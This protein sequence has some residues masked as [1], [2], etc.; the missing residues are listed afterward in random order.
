MHSVSTRGPHLQ[1]AQ[2]TSARGLRRVDPAKHRRD[3]QAPLFERR[4]MV[5]QLRRL[6]LAVAAGPLGALSAEALVS[7]SAERA[8]EA[9]RG[10]PSVRCGAPVTGHPVRRSAEGGPRPRGHLSVGTRRRDGRRH[11]LCNH[12]G[13]HPEPS[14]RQ[15]RGRGGGAADGHLQQAAL[16]PRAA[17]GPAEG[18][19]I[20]RGRI[21]RE[22]S[23]PEPPRRAG[24]VQRRG[25][26]GEQSAGQP[27][28][29]P[30]PLPAVLRL[31]ADEL[32]G[33]RG[34]PVRKMRPWQGTMRPSLGGCRFAQ[35]AGRRG[36]RRS[37]SQTRSSPQA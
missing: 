9:S 15:A 24:P 34:A 25:T 33:L 6:H 22:A 1:R 8:E 20:R 36:W 27:H 4:H 21:R 17:R 31:D 29:Q 19:H 11:Q 23:Q 3:P 12:R 32:Q 13:G 18:D 30:W 28:R 5:R 7:G 16:Q 2:E 10:T 26:L 37:S 35:R 14:R